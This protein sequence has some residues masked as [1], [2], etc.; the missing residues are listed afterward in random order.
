MMTRIRVK[1]IAA[2]LPLCI[3]AG[4][5]RAETKSGADVAAGL[6]P[7]GT[8]PA[9][10]VT[11]NEPD[12]IALP[13]PVRNRSD[14]VMLMCRTRCTGTAVVDIYDAAGSVVFHKAVGLQQPDAVGHRICIPWNCRNRNGRMVGNGTYLGVI[15]IF[16][17]ENR[18]FARH[19]V[20]IGVAY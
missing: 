15:G 8:A 12:L 5:P 4:F 19:S 1:V 2:V 18:P 14:H 7:G 3:G 10:S 16:D 9:T 6:P 11:Q 20:N 17:T 13:N